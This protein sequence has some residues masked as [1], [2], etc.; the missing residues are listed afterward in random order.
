MAVE[1]ALLAGPEEDWCARGVFGWRGGHYG[2]WVCVCLVV[3]G[4]VVEVVVR[5]DV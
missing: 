4:R 2:G 5:C 3:V 1:F